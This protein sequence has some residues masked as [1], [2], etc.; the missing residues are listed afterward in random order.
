MNGNYK[1]VIIFNEYMAHIYIYKL[2]S[3]Q[4]FILYVFTHMND[5]SKDIPQIIKMF[6]V[7]V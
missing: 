6:S 5:S 2:R 3:I 4:T 1:N 7:T